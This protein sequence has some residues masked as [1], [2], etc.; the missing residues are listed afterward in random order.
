MIGGIVAAGTIIVGF[1]AFVVASCRLSFHVDEVMAKRSDGGA[2]GLLPTIG[3]NGFGIAWFCT[4]RRME[5]F[6]EMVPERV[7][8]AVCGIV[9]TRA[10]VIIGKAF[11]R[12]RGFF[13]NPMEF[14]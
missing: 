9:A 10:G 3:T 12:A 11:F 7:L 5:I 13:S 6:D 1:M 2:G 8:M 14:L 4:R